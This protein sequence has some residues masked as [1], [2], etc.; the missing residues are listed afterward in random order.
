MK[1]P[2]LSHI[3]FSNYAII[4]T[5]AKDLNED[6]FMAR[7]RKVASRLRRTDPMIRV[8][9][10]PATKPHVSSKWFEEQLR[11]TELSTNVEVKNPFR[12]DKKK[13]V[14]RKVVSE[15][16]LTFPTSEKRV[17]IFK[18]GRWVDTNPVHVEDMTGVNERARL[19]IDRLEGK[20]HKP[21]K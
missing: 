5:S 4:F 6:Q 10:H 9:V 21:T 8:E 1:C 19:L 16:K 11:N 2:L 7:Q 3:S 12:V 20:L 14:V 13:L 18:N 15:H 17:R